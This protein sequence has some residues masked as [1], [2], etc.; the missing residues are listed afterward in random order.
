MSY[1]DRDEK[2]EKPKRIKQARST[3]QLKYRLTISREKAELREVEELAEFRAN[4][5]APSTTKRK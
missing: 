4:N 5:P 1:R 2:E 3:C